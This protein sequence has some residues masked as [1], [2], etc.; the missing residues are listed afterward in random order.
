[1]IDDFAAGRPRGS[2]DDTGRRGD[3]SFGVIGDANSPDRGA[4]L[5]RGREGNFLIIRRPSG[6]VVFR[7]I[8][9]KA[10]NCAAGDIEHPDVVAAAEWVVTIGGERDAFTVV[11]ESGFA[12][13]V[14]ADSE[15][16]L[17]AAIGRDGPQVVA[18]VAV[19][20]E[21]DP[22]TVGREDGLAGVVENVGDAFGGSA[23]GGESP[24]AA[25]QVDGEGA[26]VR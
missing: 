12:V 26:A 24:D 13:V 18:A 22:L 15:L 9:R 19:G 17:I 16:V 4:A 20:E 8:I 10:V 14:G 5:A 23:A 3:F 25:L 1:V 6:H 11:R 7:W 2:F 21:D